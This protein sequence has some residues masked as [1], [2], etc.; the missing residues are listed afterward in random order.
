MIRELLELIRQEASPAEW[1]FYFFVYC[2]LG[3]IWECLYVAVHEKH[4][5]NRGFM[6]GPLLPIYGSGAILLLAL[7]LPIRGNYVLMT[8]VGIVGASILEYVTGAVMEALFHV[9][10]WDYTGRFLNLNGYICFAS[11]ACWGAM[12]FIVTGFVHPKIAALTALI[13]G[14]ILQWADY[15]IT[16]IACV[17]FGISF[18]TAIDF[19]NV[20]IRAE[21]ARE[22]LIEL[23]R[24]MDELQ[25]QLA[26]SAADTVGKAAETAAAAKDKA[27]DTAIAA[28]DKAIDTAAAAKDK[29]IDTA[30]A[31]K[32]K[33]I[34]TAVAA[35]DKAIETA[36]AAKDKAIDTAVAAKDKAI[37][38]AVA[39]KDKAIDTAVAAR[40]R[41]AE[42]MA[43]AR[44]KAA[45]TMEKA[46]GT[47]SAAREKA[48][49]EMEELHLREQLSLTRV[50]ALYSRS[51]G[52]L[53][54]RNPGA[55]SFR[56]KE[57]FPA[58]KRALT[59]TDRQDT[60]GR[61]EVVK[62]GNDRE[63]M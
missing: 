46:A 54:K 19:R 60:G 34:D 44:E 48:I 59:G 11:T 4:F 40:E 17:D 57:V 29:A 3:W 37:D 28:K 38:T 2:F 62:A 52:S 55:V 58:V 26:E 8:V 53:L 41:A 45:G 56:Y 21:K 13:P 49:A 14:E 42:T 20:L 61:K 35:K 10:Y 51:L 27:I 18:K 43:A 32:D 7:T 47:A 16:A 22:E 36:I 31:A 6:R 39:A 25:K 24:R 30:I 1:V 23:R 12:T 33:A 50:R 63:K 15:L 9:R 5:V